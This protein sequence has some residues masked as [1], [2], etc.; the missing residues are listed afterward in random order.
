ATFLSQRQSAV[1][2]AY[3]AGLASEEGFVLIGEAL[4][5]VCEYMLCTRGTS[6]YNRLITHVDIGGG[7]GRRNP[8]RKALRHRAYMLISVRL[9][10]KSRLERARNATG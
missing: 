5:Q 2:D 1:E 7:G 9:V 8:V 4:A 3:P 6:S 10:R